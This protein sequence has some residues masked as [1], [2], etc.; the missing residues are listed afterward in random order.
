MATY[1]NI[2]IGQINDIHL[3][4]YIAGL[5]G[6]FGYEETI[7][8]APNPETKTAFAQRKVFQGT[9]KRALRYERDQAIQAIVIDDI[10]GIE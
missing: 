1:T 7:D 4:R 8:G 6:S 3:Q 2:T 5:A 10:E 9:I